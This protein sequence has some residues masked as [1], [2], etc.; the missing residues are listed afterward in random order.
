MCIHAIWTCLQRYYV[1]SN[2]WAKLLWHHW[3]SL[4]GLNRNITQPKPQIPS[5]YD[6]SCICICV[7]AMYV[8]V[9]VHTCVCFFRKDVYAHICMISISKLVSLGLLSTEILVKSLVSSIIIWERLT[10]YMYNLWHVC[11]DDRFTGFS[12]VPSTA[13]RHLYIDDVIRWPTISCPQ[14]FP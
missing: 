6:F 1:C 2:Y 9:N 3:C 5:W 8:H 13:H 7:P 14:D 11:V 12:A 4:Q 10:V